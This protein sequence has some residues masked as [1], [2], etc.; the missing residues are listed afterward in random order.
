VYPEGGGGGGSR[1]LSHMNEYLL[2]CTVS[3]QK[4]IFRI[5]DGDSKEYMSLFHV[6]QSQN[7]QLSSVRVSGWIKINYLHTFIEGKGELRNVD[8]CTN[9]KIYQVQSDSDTSMPIMPMLHLAL[10]L[11]WMTENDA[12]G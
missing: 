9:Y 6:R 7:M 8:V 10:W 3:S 12:A 1:F 5:I 4:I 11:V 2:N